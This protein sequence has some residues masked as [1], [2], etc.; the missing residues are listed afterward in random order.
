[1][2]LWIQIVALNL[3]F[4]TAILVPSLVFFWRRFKETDQQIMLLKRM[5]EKLHQASDRADLELGKNWV[6][7]Y[8]N[9]IMRFWERLQVKPEL[10]PSEEHYKSV[11]ENY[12][13][14]KQLGGMKNGYVGAIMNSIKELHRSQYGPK[15][16][17][18]TLH[19][20]IEPADK[21]K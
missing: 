2:D 5:I 11:F 1:M 12:E 14:Y 3:T 7:F 9:E 10:I 19:A 21:T 13:R 17:P 18:P 20:M 4:F 6:H 15:N 8:H 16:W